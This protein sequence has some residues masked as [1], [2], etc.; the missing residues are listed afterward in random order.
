MGVLG[1][2]PHAA[3][4][5]ETDGLEVVEGREFGLLGAA[6]FPD[7]AWVRLRFSPPLGRGTLFVASVSGNGT[8]FCDGSLL[9][10][11]E[12]NANDGSAKCGWN[13]C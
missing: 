13:P 4:E 7:R 6:G 11:G 5:T 12:A 1:P 10:P 8:V 2:T 9:G 3:A